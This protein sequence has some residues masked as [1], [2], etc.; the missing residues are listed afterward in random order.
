M[1]D[2]K[3]TVS[4]VMYDWANSAFATT[5]LAGFFPVFFKKFWSAGIDVN[6]STLMLGL[7][8]SIAGLIVAASA[9]LL[10]AIA[11]LGSKRKKFLIFFAYLGVLMTSTLFLLERGEW[12]FASIIFAIGVIGFSGANVFYDSLLPSI[13]SEDKIDYISGLGFA[14]GYLGGG[15]LFAVNVLMTQKPDLFGLESDAEAVR[16]SFLT[17]GLWW[18]LFTIPLILWVKEKKKE[19]TPSEN[20][21]LSGFRQL[22]RTFKKIRRLRMTFLFLIAYW[23][24]I[25]GVDTI[26]RMAIDFGLSIGFESSDLILALLITQFVGFPSAIAFGKLGQKWNVKKSIFIAIAVY[27]IITIFGMLMTQKYEFYIL[28]IVIG[29]VQGGVQAL[30]RSF[31][32]RLIPPN[33]EA[34][35]YGFYNMLGK[36]AVII[37]PA[38]IGVVG[39][40]V[41]NIGYSP[42]VASRAGIGSIVI[43]FILGGILLYKVDEKQGKIDV[44]NL[45]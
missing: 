7:T 21:I 4:W 32:S 43:L 37:G 10:G 29:F 40:L 23:C 16:F 25:D 2:K 3:Q 22:A 19:T 5:V 36:F 42:N 38:L 8:N 17:V 34:E 15:I 31:Y 44:Q 6:D 26:V 27:I 35:F 20:L 24:Y 13:A 39:V 41:R 11:D 30:S 1:N 9:P 45:K 28:A 14:F 33:Q 12:I 18:G